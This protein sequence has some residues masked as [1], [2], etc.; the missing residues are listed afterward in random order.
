MSAN[1]VDC[2]NCGCT[3][4]GG[5]SLPKNYDA[6]FVAVTHQGEWGAV[7]ACEM[8]FKLHAAAGDNGPAVLDAYANGFVDLENMIADAREA[9]TKI[10]KSA[11]NALFASQR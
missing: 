9:L 8:C 3:V 10:R 2:S 7:P 11:D 4:R 6:E 1:D 5:Y